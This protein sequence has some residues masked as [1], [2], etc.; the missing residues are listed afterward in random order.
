MRTLIL[1]AGAL[2]ATACTDAARTVRPDARLADPMAAQAPSPDD[3]SIWQDSLLGV[4]GEGAQY[5]FFVP[6]GWNGD[7]IFYVHGIVSPYAAVALPTG[8][9]IEVIRPALGKLGY[10]IAYSSFSENGW[11]FKD[12]LQRTTQLRGLFTSKYG[13]PRRSFLLGQS[14]GSLIVEA[15]AEERG[16]QYA[17]A[18][19]LCGAVGGARVEM[20]YIGHIRALFD[21]FYPGVM[22]GDML[23]VDGITD[24][25]QLIMP[26]L[27][28]VQSDGGAGLDTMTRI[29]Q[30]QLP[31]PPFYRLTPLLYALGYQ[32]LGANSLTAQAHGHS[33]FDNAH[34]VYADTTGLP[35]A[36]MVHVNQVVRRYASSPDAQQF[37]DHDYQPTGD[38]RIPLYTVHSPVDPLVPLVHE[39]SLRAYVMRA[40][41][42]DMLAQ[43]YPLRWGHCDAF[44]V[45]DVVDAFQGLVHW[46]DTGEKPAQ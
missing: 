43:S 18:L 10:A 41:R 21:V 34:T 20:Q 11:A 13:K 46:V 42:L 1:V 17:G 8:D 16:S 7:V 29:Q 33:V 39:D 25:N 6:K 9:S 32:A 30:G 12:G 37:L 22:P 26:V 38:L 35:A 23:H 15:I 24:R 44:W 28:A 2:L 4:T 40:G 45:H 5:A 36:T 19:A 3:A 31:G 27:M 14:L